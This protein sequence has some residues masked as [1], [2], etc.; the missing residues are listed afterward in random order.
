MDWNT[1]LLVN[2]VLIAALNLA[3]LLTVP[4]RTWDWI[5]V[6]AVIL[7]AA[8]AAW[9]LAP[10][11]AGYLSGA[12][13]GLFM[14]AP[15]LLRYRINRLVQSEHFA[16]AARLASISFWLHPFG[17]QR[18]DSDFLRA[19]L[20]V[21]NGDRDAALAG[22]GRLS[23]A[24]GRAG[25]TARLEV[26]RLQRAWPEILQVL[27]QNIGALHFASHIS[28]LPTYLR[29]LAETG[30]PA[31]M[32]RTYRY[33]E[34]YLDRQGFEFL[35]TQCRIVLF[36]FTGE[37]SALEKVLATTAQVIR[38]DNRALMLG[39]AELAAGRTEAAKARLEPLTHSANSI[40][41][42]GARD[43]LDHH[44]VA[45][46]PP[47]LPDER[48]FVSRLAD[49]IDHEVRL[50]KPAARRRP[51]PA[52]TWTLVALNLAMFSVEVA[53][54]GSESEAT[55]LRLGA[56]FT[57]GFSL[58]DSWR[59]F[60]ANF[61]HF[62]TAHLAFN[63][64]ALIML[65]PLVERLCGTL[66][67]IAI[68]VISGV[69]AMLGVVSAAQFGLISD[70]LLV[71]ASGAIMGLVGAQAAILLREHN[72]GARVASRGLRNIGFVVATQVIFDQLMPQVSGT[73]HL[74]GLAIGFLTTF[75]LLRLRSPAGG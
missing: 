16:A 6:P 7:A 47:L 44:L 46:G 59:L 48:N 35:R 53:K 34:R 1:V 37:V 43:R 61:L 52:A 32:V 50:F 26:L 17:Q 5:A 30:D 71:G 41:A 29:A 4:S 63:M 2:A 33:Y 12:L 25:L 62:G 75:G 38:P 36:T 15:G 45:I 51:I 67:F 73:A 39:T 21:F 18:H 14:I 65:G 27:R 11:F 56:V 70:A 60:S 23:K 42:Q 64:L 55:L 72:K 40:V 13:C 20:A 49:E 24:S 58:S 9:L 8:A 10:N 22:F 68:Y 69:G 57:R 66:R 28:L 74:G 3:R 19:R 54:G 31:T